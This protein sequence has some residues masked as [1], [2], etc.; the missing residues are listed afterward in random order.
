M[1]E[2]RIKKDAADDIWYLQRKIMNENYKMQWVILGQ[3]NSFGYAHQSKK[4][5][6]NETT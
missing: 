3:Y 2:Y 6:E 5:I 1:G 4:A